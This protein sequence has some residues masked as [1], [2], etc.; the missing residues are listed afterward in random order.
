MTLRVE[1][2]YYYFW[3]KRKKKIADTRNY[4]FNASHAE[5]S[6]NVH[7]FRSRMKNPRRACKNFSCD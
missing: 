3:Q 1:Q 5:K 4:E 7:P 6:D 2:R